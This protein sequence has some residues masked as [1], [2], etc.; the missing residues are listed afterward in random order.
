MFMQVFSKCLTI[1]LLWIIYTCVDAQCDNRSLYFDGVNDFVELPGGVLPSTTS[2]TIEFWFKVD[3][4]PLITPCTSKYIY[5]L[6]GTA[7]VHLYECNGVLKVDEVLPGGT[8]SIFLGATGYSPGT[9][10]HMLIKTAPGTLDFYFDCQLAGSLAQNAIYDVSAE[11][12]LGASD[13][14]PNPGEVFAGEIDEFRIWNYP[15]TQ[16][17]IDKE[18]HCVAD[19]SKAG[20]MTYY[21]FDQGVANDPTNYPANDNSG[22]LTAHDSGPYNHD[23][24]LVNFGLIGQTSNFICSNSPMIYPI[25]E[26]ID[27]VITDYATRLDTLRMICSGDPFHLC[28]KDTSGN[29]ISTTGHVDTIVWEYNNGAGWTPINNNALRDYCFGVDPNQFTIDCSTSTLG[30]EDWMIRCAID[31][32]NMSGDS[33]WYYTDTTSLRIM[34]PLDADLIGVGGPHCENDTTDY[35]V[36]ITSNYPFITA[37]APSIRIDWTFTDGNGSLPLPS[38]EDMTQATL[39]GIVSPPGQACFSAVV[40]DTISGKSTTLTSCATIEARPICGK[41][42]ADTLFGSIY[43]FDLMEKVFQMCRCD[44]AQLYATTPFLNSHYI[45]QYSQDKITW[46]DFVDNNPLANTNKLPPFSPGDTVYVRVAGYPLSYPSMP[47]IC[48]PCYSDTLKIAMNSPVVADTI[49]GPD[50]LCCDSS[51][52]L[53]IQSFDPS[54]NHTWYCNGDSV[55]SN[56][57]M[58]TTTMGGRYYVVSS[59]TCTSDTTAYKYVHPCKVTPIITCP[60]PP[61]VCPNVGETIY[62]SGCSSSSSCPGGLTYQWSWDSGTLIAQSGCDLQHIPDP[63]GTTYTLTVTNAQGCTSTTTRTIVPCP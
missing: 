17:Q 33:C 31:A 44:D 56:V 28:L 39:L 29:A 11:Q 43:T 4:R 8:Q 35:T 37:P 9:W 51:I 25:F 36:N 60:L 7:N 5:T 23:G 55:A 16:M 3:P 53:S 34:C 63:G 46:G 62:L 21:R 45:W 13:N 22:I 6:T 14:P 40:S 57:N 48:D 47:F 19:T 52:V 32:E 58:I 50:T 61:N 54:L 42:M 2:F 18:K 30:Y 27:P 10:H 12:Y 59:D 24:L 1:L 38:F 49:I 26:G 15:K 41:I 20:L